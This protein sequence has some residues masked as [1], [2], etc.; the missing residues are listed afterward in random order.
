[1]ESVAM[2]LSGH[3]LG[4]VHTAAAV[5]ALVLGPLYAFAPLPRKPHR[6]LADAYFG[7]MLLVP[8]LFT[9]KETID[10]G[11]P[12][13]APDTKMYG[14]EPEDVALPGSATVNVPA[15]VVY[16]SD[17]THSVCAS[18]AHVGHAAV[19]APAS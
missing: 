11:S 5:G 9:V 4:T 12:G 7:A 15:A 13:F 17:S 10:I 1:M 19:A 18:D 14:A 16:D 6:Q 8:G 3:L 2:T